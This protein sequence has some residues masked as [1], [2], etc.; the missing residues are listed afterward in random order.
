MNPFR[1]PVFRISAVL[2][3]AALSV[4]P[5]ALGQSAASLHGRATD[6][7]G[8]PLANTVVRLISDQTS[9]SGHTWRYTL[10]GDSLG[11]FSQEGLAPGAYLVMLFTDGKGSTVLQHLVL[12]AGEGTELDFKVRSGAAVQMAGNDAMPMDARPK[13]RALT[14]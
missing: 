6:E 5:S 8:R 10:M 3:G 7:S 2:F 14:R 12:K 11:K 13:T 9:R 1:L 4:A